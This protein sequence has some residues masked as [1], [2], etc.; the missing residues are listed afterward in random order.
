[1]N[2]YVKHAM[3]TKINLLTVHY[4]LHVCCYVQ[5]RIPMLVMTHGITHVHVPVWYDLTAARFRLIYQGI[6]SVI[7]GR[8]RNQFIETQGFGPIILGTDWIYLFTYTELGSNF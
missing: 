8:T 5:P 4:N 1:M 6:H 3:K 2:N 7:K